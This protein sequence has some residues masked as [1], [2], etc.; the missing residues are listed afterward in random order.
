MSVLRNP[1]SSLAG[2]T[3]ITLQLQHRLHSTDV[4]QGPVI[5]WVEGETRRWLVRWETQE[6]LIPGSQIW[7][8]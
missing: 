7:E 5:R 2:R 3:D 1:D 4:L 6:I 8:P